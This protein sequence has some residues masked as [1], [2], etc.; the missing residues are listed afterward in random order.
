[1]ASNAPR[2]AFL[3]GIVASTLAACGDNTAAPSSSDPQAQEPKQEL[4]LC[5]RLEPPELEPSLGA[6]CSV[7]A[8]GE[9][10]LIKG[11]V[12]TPGKTYIGGQVAFDAAGTITCVGCNCAA[13]GETTITCPQGVISPGLINTHEHLTFSQT[14]PLM[15]T[16]ERFEHRNDWRAGLRGHTELV[17][18]QD[19]NDD[20]V[21]Y[22]ELRGLVAGTTS[23]NGSG[24]VAGLQ[25]NLDRNDR[26]EGIDQPIVQYQ[27]FPLT[28]GASDVMRRSTCNY[29]ASGD[30]NMFVSTKEAYTPHV[31]EGIDQEARNEFLCTSSDTYD[32][33]MPGFSNDVMLA[34]TAV[35][36]GTGMVPADYAVMAQ[37]GSALIWSPRT[38]VSLYGNTAQVTTAAR[39]GIEIALGTDWLPSGSTNMLRELKCA[40]ELNKNYY[41]NFFSDA[42]LWRMATINAASALAMD[43]A[44]GVLAEGK[45]A[46]IAIFDGRERT[47]FRAVIDA[48][49]KDVTLVIR[50]GKPLYGDEQL[51]AKLRPTGC[52]QIDVCGVTKQLCLIDEIG[53]T[54]PQLRASLP[55]AAV[56]VP[57]PAFYCGIPEREPT[58][59]PSRMTSVND[60][61]VYTGDRT[62]SDRDGDGIA[63]ASDNCPRIFNPVRPLDN[64][65]QADADGD[66]EGD[67]C[68]VCPLTAD[69]TKCDAPTAEDRDGDGLVN[70]NDN[71]PFH[72]NSKQTD[73]DADGKGDACDECPNAANLGAT[74]CPATIY[75]VK[76]GII[77]VDAYVTITNALVTGKGSNG[78]FIQVKEGDPGYDGPNYSGLFVF[79]TNATSLAAAEV[80]GRV[81]VEGQMTNFF[82]QLE[83][84][85]TVA[86]SRVGDSVEAAPAPTPATLAEIGVGGSK[87]LALES[88]IVQT[89]TS[90][91]TAVN[92]GA[93]EF[94]ATAAA[95]NLFVDDFLFVNPNFPGVNQS[96]AT[97][98]GI[99]AFR[100][101]GPRL[102]PRGP[103]DLNPIA[104]LGAIS[105]TPAF[106]RVGQT[107]VAAFPTPLTV[108]L[109]M[110]VRTPTFVTV[111][112]A[113]PDSLAVVGGGVT[114]P[115]GQLSAP[116]KLTGVVQAAAVNLTASLAGQ[117]ETFT[118]PVRVLGDAEVPSTVTI[119]P[120]RVRVSPGANATVSVTLDL[121]ATTGGALVTLAL[122]PPTAGTIPPSVLVA[123]NQTSATFVYTNEV[124]A[125]SA[126]LMASFA[127]SNSSAAVVQ[128]SPIRINELDYDQPGTG[129]AAEFIELYNTSP[130]VAA[131]LSN[132]SVVFVNGSSSP[133]P[134][135][136]TVP[137]GPANGGNPLPPGGYL[138]IAVATLPVEPGSIRY[139][140]ATGWAATD[141]I[142][143]GSPDGVLLL[144]TAS[145]DIVDAFSYEGSIT[146]ATVAGFTDPVSL[147]EG[148]A[149]P[150]NVTD[151]SS[152]G[153]LCR[154]P[155]G[156]DTNNAA[157][158]WKFCASPTAGKTNAL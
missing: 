55:T 9:T 89:A 118:A 112:S 98:A 68:D 41:D 63:N 77:P 150:N 109:T 154:F 5:E 152:T 126:T 86:V 138:V 119:S 82:G 108:S 101:G 20:R 141:N 8:G 4:V 21:A 72:T 67:A 130:V 120:A 135:Y 80:G 10:R 6:V 56:P 131:N 148:T 143:N 70:E 151:T 2:L 22:S 34:Q 88:V 61:T 31:S 3:L 83:I 39:F 49:P 44:I 107:D 136:K 158:D 19:T 145:L 18:P 58:C 103:E 64:G 40:D 7:E 42:A 85:N 35:I 59:K 45:A 12:L 66:G 30:S 149:L 127:A 157:N 122:N 129:D 93:G 11:T 24:D 146:A 50:G 27:T 14:P 155:N 147:V 36:H 102:E 90:T 139:T 87:V 73:A 97:L 25:R 38:N 144:N 32:A 117:T 95:L 51:I 29:G 43:D 28:R 57:Y 1:M 92:T 100:N 65:Q 13:G 125:D 78:F 47:Q 62:D 96:Y 156:Q 105:S 142:Q 48:Q 81:N 54:W 46:D 26:L 52:D 111:T 104:R 84:S 74:S 106:I 137:L 115:A 140:P 37:R 124:T 71:C 69:S 23:V 153:S 91:V 121:P 17:A 16:G 110:P 53:K 113:D 60:S 15:D 75:A 79:T 133:A 114:I 94:T 134:T 76:K 128:I 116:V 99:L 123:E 132:L 33:D